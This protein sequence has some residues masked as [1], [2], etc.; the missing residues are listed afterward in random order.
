VHVTINSVAYLV[1]QFVTIQEDTPL[2]A[3]II[4]GTNGVNASHFSGTAAL[5]AVSQGA[6]GTTSFLPDGT[7]TYTPNGDY[8]L[9]DEITY[10]V[11]SGGVSET[12]TLG[13]AVTPSTDIVPD[14]LATDEDTPITSNLITGTNGASADTFIGPVTLLG[15]IEPNHGT[16]S[17]LPDGTMTYTPNPDFYGTETF[18][19]SIQSAGGVENGTVTVTVNQVDDI[20]PDFLNT[21]EGVPITANLITGTAGAS[22]DNFEGTAN[23]V[24]VT[25]GDHGTVTF[26]PDG[27]VTY[28]PDVGFTG[29]DH[30]FYTAFSGGVAESAMVTVT[31]TAIVDIPLIV[32]NPAIGNYHLGRET[33]LVDPTATFAPASTGS[34]DFS[35]ATLTVQVT[36]GLTK[37]TV[38]SIRPNGKAAGQINLMHN[39]VRYGTVVIGTFRGGSGRF[40][41]FVVEFNGDATT[42]AVTAVLKRINYQNDRFVSEFDVQMQLSNVSGQDSNIAARHFNTLPAVQSKSHKNTHTS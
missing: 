26:E 32:L 20:V 40:P 15:F 12:G 8:T 22:P 23:I 28:T 27:T 41:N 19:Y 6:H 37:K 11:T 33:A 9:F 42:E 35:H 38:L 10:T 36:S 7:I 24:S 4:T 31:A 21:L 13:I 14:S 1:T 25:Q 5:T 39:K 30:F 16:V 18:L 29:D 3:N 34:A 17:F 2:V